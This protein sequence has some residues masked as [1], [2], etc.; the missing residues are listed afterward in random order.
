[1]FCKCANSFGWNAI[2]HAAIANMNETNRPGERVGE[3]DWGKL[4]E[5]TLILLKA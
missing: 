4:N 1:M 2:I 3:K 5:I